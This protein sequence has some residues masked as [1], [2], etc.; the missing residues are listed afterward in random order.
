MVSDEKKKKNKGT[1]FTQ[2]PDSRGIVTVVLMSPNQFAGCSFN[3]IH[4]N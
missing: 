4:E 2:T 3:W 1:S